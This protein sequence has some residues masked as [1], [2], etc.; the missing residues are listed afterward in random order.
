MRYFL[1]FI[2]TL[3]MFSVSCTDKTDAAAESPD[4]V[5]DGSAEQNKKNPVR[6]VRVEVMKP[7]DT[8]S[9]IYFNAII[10]AQRDVTVNSKI[11]GETVQMNYD[12]GSFVR[13]GD[14]VAAVEFD[15]QKAALDQAG[16]NLKQAELNFSLKERVF[17]RDR[18]LFENKAVSTESFE[19]SENGYKTAEL[20]LNQAKTALA[21]A[22]I[23]YNNCFIK[24]PFDGVIAER[25]VQLGQYVTIGTV[26]ARIVDIANLQVIVG[27]TFE[28]LLT[29]KKYKNRNIDIILP[30]GSTAPGSVKGV[31]EAPDRKTGLYSMK[32]LFASVKD[33]NERYT[34]FPGM[35]LK[36]AMNGQVHKNAFLISRNYI[37]LLG[38]KY[39]IYVS[40]NGKAV[41]KEVEIITDDGKLRIARFTDGHDGAFRLIITGIDALTDGREI[42]EME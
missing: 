3:S 34:V 33:D 38:T 7:G 21:T 41:E 27:L 17:S 13:K 8:A 19:I 10:E 37:R 2:F 20:A 5:P 6:K 26:I 18:N 32:V 42:E 16:L 22:E 23:N 28:E 14:T 9:K 1:I 25:P 36:V 35:Q 29:Y 15:A 12:I 11:T 31:A 4:T 24:A 39:V 30:D 40:Q